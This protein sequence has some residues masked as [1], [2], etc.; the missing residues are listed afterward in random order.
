MQ[1]D[2]DAWSNIATVSV[3]VQAVNEAPVARN[4]EIAATAGFPIVIDVLANDS[5]SDGFLDKT[6]LELVN[7][8]DH[9]PA[10][11]DAANGSITYTAVSDFSGEDSFTYRVRDDEGA[12]SNTATVTI[13]VEA[14][15]DG[16]FVFEAA[17]DGQVKVTDPDKNYG[18]KSSTKVDNG[19]FRTY[20]KFRVSGVSGQVTQ[21]RLRL[22]VG[23]D[24]SDGSEDGGDLFSVSNN[25]D[26]TSTAWDEDDL[27]AGNA[28]EVAGAAIAQ[29]GEVL[30]ATV[31]EL[32]LG[33]VL[34]GDGTYSFAIV[35][36]S[37]DMVRYVTKEGAQAPLLIIETGPA[38]GN[39]PPLARDD[40]VTTHAGI[41]AVI[42][43]LGNDEDVDGSLDITSINIVS[44]VGHGTLQVNPNSG[45]IT[46]HPDFGYVGADGFGY[47][48]QD[49]AGAESNEAAVTI[50]IVAA[51]EP[52]TLTFQ[53]TDD[54]QVKLTDPD[55][56]YSDKSS[57]KS[58]QSSFRG[59][60]KFAVSGVT[61]P[62]ER[63]ELRLVVGDGSSD[64]SEDGGALYRVDNTFR[65]STSS[66]TESLLNA[67]NAPA[68]DE[69]LASTGAVS[70]GAHVTFDV[71]SVVTTNG[72]YSFAIKNESADLVAYHSKE[73]DVAPELVV[74]FLSTSAQEDDEAITLTVQAPQRAA[75]DMPREFA[76]HSNYPNPFNTATTISYALPEQSKVDLAIFNARG[77]LVRRLAG[78]VQPAGFRKLTW[79]GR[80]ESGAEVASGVYFLRMMVAD[81]VF[82]KRLVLQK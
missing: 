13:S 3:E 44:P 48:V 47:T 42:D 61:G 1:D 17:E 45:V 24:E 69:V 9:G 57:F 58:E 60:L 76:L 51:S 70:P 50:D 40:H 5:D 64:G 80:D 62:V 54:A 26:G 7:L 19:V 14:A 55:K 28:P 30:P 82:T 71:T 37:T 2:D 35:S 6:S 74:V 15:E 25:Y 41:A 56:N 52:V 38:N 27:T 46:Y 22:E 72:T 31:V 78:A 4:D 49:D 33:P 8:P 36:Q 73:G 68:L 75:D 67:G 34:A 29:I 21:V 39:Q 81:Q 10:S 59:Y 65:E 63:A 53:P 66:W 18:D 12:S 32:A 43:V 11:V 16:V 77:Q 20:L 79:L 23:D